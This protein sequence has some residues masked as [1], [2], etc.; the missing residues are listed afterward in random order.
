MS[1]RA[2]KPETSR[3]LLFASWALPSVPLRPTPLW[4]RHGYDQSQAVSFSLSF[5]RNI[6][7]YFIAT[8]R[9]EL[10]SSFVFVWLSGL[11]VSALGIRAR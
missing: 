11:V 10:N 3:T 1:D 2:V 8:E 4:R 5:Y 6:L 7:F 9:E